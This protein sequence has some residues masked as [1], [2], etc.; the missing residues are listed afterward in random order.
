M[1]FRII[2][3][4]KISFFTILLG[5]LLNSC[6]G[7]RLESQ[8]L[9]YDNDFS[10]LDLAGIVNAKLFIFQG[11]TLLGFFN[12]EESILTLND[13]PGH[14]VVKI[15]VEV[16][17]H[18][19]WDGNIDDGWNGPDFW[20]MK[21]D[22]TEVFRTTF[23]NTPCEST[24]C[25]RQSYPDNFLRQHF[26]KTGAI[27][28]NLPGLCLFGAFPNYTTRYRI[29]QMAPHTGNSISITFGDELFQFENPNPICD[30]S[31]S[32]NRIKVTTMVVI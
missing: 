8:E 4:F 25:V 27:Q 14:N 20:Y 12:N 2:S 9:V 7:D 5:V 26:P 11:D 22:D 24:F 28:T 16:L 32:I 17:A 19:S 31:W 6:H 23:S 10:T 21:V 29:V 15:E 13:L 3:I 30:E 18:D 1:K